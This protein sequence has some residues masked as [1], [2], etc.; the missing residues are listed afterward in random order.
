MFDW[1]LNI[2]S[3]ALLWLNGYHIPWLD[4]FVMVFS[5]KFIWVPMYMMLLLVFSYIYSIQR[6]WLIVLGVILTIALADQICATVIRPAVERLRP[7]NP[8]NPLSEFVTLVNGYRGGAYGFPSCHAANSFAL[9]AFVS[10]LIRNR[11]TVGYVFLWATLNSLSRTYLG[12]HYPGDLIVGASIGLCCGFF[13]AWLTGYA[14]KRIYGLSTPSG[15]TLT[16]PHFS[17]PLGVNMQH[18]LLGIRMVQIR[19]IDVFPVAGLL[20]V[21]AMAVAAL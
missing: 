12:V 10:M 14:L 1:I 17:L 18:G 15:S 7:S 2:D 4:A 8:D 19:V 20:T 5:S 21:V 6:V 11:S 9:A 16:A 3:Q 13:A